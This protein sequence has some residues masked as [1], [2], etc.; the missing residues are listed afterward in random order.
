MVDRPGCSSGA[1]ADARRRRSSASSER[2]GV[3]VA[4]ASVEVDAGDVASGSTPVEHV[5]DDDRRRCRG[6]RWRLAAATSASA[7]A[8]GWALASDDRWISSSSTSSTR[9]SLHSTKRSP[10][11]SGSTHVSTR[12]VGSMPRARVTML[13][14][15]WLRASAS[16]MWPVA[17][18][19]LHVAVID[20]GAAQLAGADEVRAAVADVDER[21]LVGPAVARGRARRSR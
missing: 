12:T 21:E 11:T 13:R 19:L 5:D 9:P 10:R 3:V 20:G 2:H 16:V 1:A 8:C 14:R 7:A 6:R 15:G 18:Q 17:T 4:S